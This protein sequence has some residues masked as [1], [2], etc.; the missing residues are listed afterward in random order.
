MKETRKSLPGRNPGYGAGTSL[1]SGST[2]DPALLHLV[3][4]ICR[5]GFSLVKMLSTIAESRT[6]L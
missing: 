2:R 4:P 5:L 1:R 3:T 6:R